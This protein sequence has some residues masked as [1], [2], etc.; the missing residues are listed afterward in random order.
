VK[1]RELLRALDAAA[2]HAQERRDEGA[3]FA[4]AAHA[5][6][7]FMSGWLASDA[8]NGDLGAIQ[9]RAALARIE[10]RP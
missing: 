5:A 10:G 7:C 9:A 8:A 2:D 1:A 3:Y 4:D 6:I